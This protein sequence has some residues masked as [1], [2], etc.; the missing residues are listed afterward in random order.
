MANKIAPAKNYTAIL[1]AVYQRETVPTVLARSS[2]VGF[3]LRL[4][5]GEPAGFCRL[6]RDVRALV[7]AR[8]M[9]GSLK[10]V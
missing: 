3:E 6:R 2:R 9:P 10:D 7:D 1:D 4:A 8:E 5:C